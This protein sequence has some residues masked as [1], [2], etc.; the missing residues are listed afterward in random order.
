MSA[1][2]IEFEMIDYTEQPLTA[3]E[4][5]TYWRASGLTLKKFFNTSGILYRE[6]HIK[7][8]LP[9]MNEDE[10]LKLLAANPMLV[11]RPI[12]VLEQTVLVG[13]NETQWETAL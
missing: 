12:L 11:K 6:L 13:F 9:Q 8:R 3:E 1:R 5:R 7:E 10:Q 2:G 4:L